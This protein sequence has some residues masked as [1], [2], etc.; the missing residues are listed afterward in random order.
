GPRGPR[1]YFYM[2]PWPKRMAGLISTLSCKFSQNDIHVVDSFES[3]PL[4][5]TDAHLGELCEARGWGPSVLFVDRMDLDMAPQC[6]KATHF[7]KATQTIKHINV[8]P[9]YGLNVFSMLKH[10][11][12]VLTVDAIKDIESKLLL[13]LKRI[14]LKNVIFKYKPDGVYRL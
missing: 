12:L 8:V 4:D 1:S 3:F 14:D 5:G 10:E 6:T 9:M 2:L 7:Y 11:T 13:Q